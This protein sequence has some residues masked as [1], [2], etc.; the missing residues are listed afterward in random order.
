MSAA[1]KKLK[2]ARKPTATPAAE[3]QLDLFGD[4]EETSAK[5]NVSYLPVPVAR[6]APTEVP[7]GRIAL[8]PMQHERVPL[9]MEQTWYFEPE[10]GWDAPVGPDA[11]SDDEILQLMEALIRESLRGLSTERRQS[12]KARRESAAWFLVEGE[13]DWGLSFHQCCRAL[14]YN[15]EEIRSSV[16]SLCK[17]EGLL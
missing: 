14:G 7:N 9:G 13:S 12:R 2:P 6:S 11:F 5:S 15:E 10:D 8:K 3:N 4:L 1:I 16:R 17:A